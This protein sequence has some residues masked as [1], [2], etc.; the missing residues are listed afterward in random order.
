ML[1]VLD[2]AVHKEEQ[3]QPSHTHEETP[4]SYLRRGRECNNG[5]LHHR[6]GAHAG[7]SLEKAQKHDRL[8]LSTMKG[9]GDF[10]ISS[11]STGSL[12]GDTE[13]DLLG[14]SGKTEVQ[15]PA[16]VRESMLMMGKR[17]SAR[18]DVPGFLRKGHKRQRCDQKASPLAADASEG[19]GIPR[20]KAASS[21]QMADETSDDAH[22]RG[23]KEP[24]KRGKS[25]DLS[26]YTKACRTGE[27]SWE[28]GFTLS[29][30]SAAGVYLQPGR[31][32][33][34]K[35]AVT[36]ARSGNIMVEATL[37]LAGKMEEK[38]R[39]KRASF[40]TTRQEKHEQVL[41]G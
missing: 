14:D 15:K 40:D 11:S 28:R 29:T 10:V 36:L 41:Q 19:P 27:I 16:N 37:G 20:G 12:P 32:A 9:P 4:I 26:D 6:V 30:A 38:L 2:D 7:A 21:A 3:L 18:E 39:T 8:E 13:G 25:A 34:A 23:D 22:R 17:P 35:Q 24:C 1:N 5:R 31:T 33:A